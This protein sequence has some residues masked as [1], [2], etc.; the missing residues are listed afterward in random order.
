[1]KKEQLTMKNQKAPTRKYPSYKDSGIE[2]LG[3]VPAHWEVRRL[4][5][6][7]ESN[8][9]VRIPNQLTENDLIEFVPMT[10]VNEELG[11]ITNYNF[12]PLKEVISGYTKFKNG[13]I[14]FAKITPCMENGNCAIVS[15]LKYNIG[16]GSTEFMI[17][18][19]SQRLTKKYLHYFLHNALFRKN[20]EPFMKGSAG[21][22][23]ITSL[24]MTTHCFALPPIPEQIAIANYLDTHTAKIDKKIE[25]LTKKAT[26]YANLKQSLINETVTRGLSVVSTHITRV[27]AGSEPA[28]TSQQEPAP[29]SAATKATLS[30]KGNTTPK[31]KDS[32]IEWIGEIPEHWEV[33]RVKDLFNERNEKGFPEEII[34]IASQDRGVVAKASYER[35][36][37][38]VQKDFHLMKL[39]K[40]NDY[41][42][43]LRSFEGGIEIAHQ[44]GIIRAVYTV[45]YSINNEMTNYYKHLFKSKKFILLLVTLTTGIR[46]GRNINYQELKRDFLPLPPLHEQAAIADYLDNKT[47][48]IEQIIEKIHL[49]IEKLKELRK[50]LVNDVVTGKIRVADNG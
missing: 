32:G 45:L 18:R 5:D 13:D 17:F 30:S 15:G 23:R 12:V 42:I 47:K 41:V 22:K 44:Q 43:S 39:V 36:S 49:Q 2:W 37:M 31:M 46:D 50:A 40:K 9:S 24:Y 25:L 16:F 48:S 11:I 21:Q 19:S 26:L 38:T 34:L 14:I 20:A 3:E 27:R 4:K 33:K 28:P 7:T 1:M 29:T 10:N 6:F 8:V 35:N